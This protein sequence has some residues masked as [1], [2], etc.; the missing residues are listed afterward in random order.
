MIII[1]YKEIVDYIIET[2][3]KETT[4]F[5]CILSYSY[6]EKEFDIKLSSKIIKQIELDLLQRE[7]IADVELDDYGFDV[8]LYTAYSPNYIEEE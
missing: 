5:Q 4:S 7:E 2:V 1:N 6:I 3:Q 8:V